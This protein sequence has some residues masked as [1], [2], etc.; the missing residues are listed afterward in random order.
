MYSFF[1]DNPIIINKKEK[2]VVP[3]ETYYNR[4]KKK[5]NVDRK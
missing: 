2:T 1:T 4:E 3:V 5:T